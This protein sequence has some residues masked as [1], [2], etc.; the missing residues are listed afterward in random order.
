MYRYLQEWV[1]S[2][3][4]SDTS[5]KATNHKP[6]TLNGIK[7]NTTIPTAPFTAYG[8]V[9][10]LYAIIF[11]YTFDLLYMSQ[12]I[13]PSLQTLILPL[14]AHSLAHRIPLLPRGIAR[15]AG[16]SVGL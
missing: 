13:P 1:E 11:T 5:C 15:L 9:V 16:Q 3:H 2:Y 7:W 8:K 14:L 4:S 10:Q 12:A 6:Y